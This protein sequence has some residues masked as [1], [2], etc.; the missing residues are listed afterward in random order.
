MMAQK[1][2]KGNPYKSL[3]QWLYDNNDKSSIPEDVLEAT[4]IGPQY[5]LYF[6]RASKYSVLINSIFNNYYIFSLPKKDVL[7][8]IKWCV[9]RT[10]FKPR[11]IPKQKKTDS[12]L[13]KILRQKYPLLKEY[14]I[15]QLI[16]Y[17]EN[18]DDKDAIYE[19]FGLKKGR[20]SS[21]KKG[22]KKQKN[23]NENK[24]SLKSLKEHFEI[25]EV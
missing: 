10:K 24:Y 20:K 11:F 25:K 4:N 9:R 2:Q 12:K 22:N 5:I 17:I 1:N 13:G 8:L 3:N 14:E 19:A 15:L 16:D 7:K 18:S 6:F 23:N 21:S